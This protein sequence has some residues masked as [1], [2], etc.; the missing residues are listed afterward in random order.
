MYLLLLLLVKNPGEVRSNHMFK[1]S[2]NLRLSQGQVHGDK[3]CLSDDFRLEE[4]HL[5]VAHDRHI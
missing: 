3:T 1:S 5:C 2:V 4:Q